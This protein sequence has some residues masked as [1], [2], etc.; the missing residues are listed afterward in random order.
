[1][2]VEYRSNNS[3]GRWWLG[4]EDWEALEKAGWV[5]NWVKDKP[6]K[7]KWSDE[8][9]TGRFLGALAVS[10]TRFGLPL[11][12]A[13]REW[14]DITGECSTDAGCACCGKPHD[15]TEYDDAGNYVASGPDDS[16]SVS[17]TSAGMTGIG[18]GRTKLKRGC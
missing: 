11:R 1:M 17:W 14:E 12:D 4:D 7:D 18:T 2:K 15:F 6:E 10:A 9:K 5:V 8:K 16:Y 13:V 3:G